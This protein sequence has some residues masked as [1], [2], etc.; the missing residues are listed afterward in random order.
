M[1]HS[2]THSRRPLLGAGAR[3][4]RFAAV[5]IAALA[6][7]ALARPAAA[8][9]PT[10]EIQVYDASIAAP[11][12]INLTLHTNF[13][14]D[15]IN[16]AAFPGA[17]V[18]ND[19]FDGGFEWAYGAKPWLELGLYLPL[20]SITGQYGGTIN[21]GKVRLL[22]VSPDADERKFFYGM[23]FEFSY[24][25]A[26]W[27]ARTYTSEIRPIFGWH[28][29]NRWDF[30][31]NPILDNSWRGGFA[32]LAFNPAARVAYHLN[33]RWAI[34]AEQYSGFGDLNQFL[35]DTEQV[36]QVWAVFDHY[37]TLDIEGGIGFGLTPASDK[38]TLKLMFSRD[39]N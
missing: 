19:S 35:P 4:G 6:A 32:A 14:P 26:K 38:V 2:M 15:G 29:H 39:L 18:S 27:D 7:A 30:I 3:A 28:L 37:S 34:A 31:F 16:V 12:K 8:Q 33:P 36:Q 17:I 1:T 25:S 22:F 20:Y 10:D 13:T 11:G 24:N 5:L 21:G 23:N 9:G